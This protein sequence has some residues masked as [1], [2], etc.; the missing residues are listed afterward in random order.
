M[1]RGS[2]WFR[3]QHRYAPY[4]FVTPFVVV[5]L[6][7]GLYPLVKSVW[8]SFYIT[9][10]PR[11]RVFVGLANF[12]FL[13]RDPDFGKAVWNTTV[14]AVFSV[15]LQLPLSLGLALLLNRTA[16]RGRNFFRLV[17][18]SPRLVG[19][20]FAAVLFVVIFQP[21]FGLLNRLL[22]G[23]SRGGLEA[24][25]ELVAVPAGEPWSW[26]FVRLLLVLAAP[27]ALLLGRMV[28]VQARGA[29]SRPV[30][31]RRV[32]PRLLAGV[33]G[34]VAVFVLFC[35]HGGLAARG[36]SGAEPFDLDT[37]W[38]GNPALV[39]PALVLTALWMYVGFN[40]IYFLAALQAVN[41]DLYDAAK[42]DGAN[43]FQQF[44]HVTLPGIK[45]VAVFVVVLSTI[46]SFKLF[47]LPYLLLGNSGGPEN[48]GL[49]IVMYLY[50]NGFETGDLGYA[51]AIGWT[52]ALGVLVI[53][54]VQMRVAGGWK[55]GD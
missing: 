33:A 43:A 13:F 36:V 40:M 20:V 50:Q 3:L 12:A 30:L 16:L 11:S 17:F 24:L 44:L 6:L 41:Q 26:P 37:K 42:V 49:T 46:G 14:F 47:E 19:M 23:I 27:W 48:A 31:S 52:L 35:P 55:R 25:R 39:M 10:G 51:S 28:W 32:S 45:P 2:A 53:S 1:A 7:F 34:A 54:L 18:F 8:L 21:Q 15:F 29:E 5:F 4:F 38:L 9:S 22:H